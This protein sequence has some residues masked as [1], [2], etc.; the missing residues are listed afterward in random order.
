[1]DLIFLWRRQIVNQQTSNEWYSLLLMQ[2]PEWSFYTASQICHSSAIS[3]CCCEM[4]PYFTRAG[5]LQ[6]P[7]VWS[8]ARDPSDHSI[9]VYS[10]PY[11]LY[12]TEH[13]PSSGPLCYLFPL[14]GMP[15]PRC[16]LDQI[17]P[18]S[19]VSTSTPYLEVPY[20]PHSGTPNPIT[21]LNSFK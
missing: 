9:I 5:A 15:F 17:L 3:T 1:M 10:S 13:T 12:S 18:F 16:L 20:L 11:F 2:Q 4:T 21:L 19:M 6:W 7:T 8:Q 14:P